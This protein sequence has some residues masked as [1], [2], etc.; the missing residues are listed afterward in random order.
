L[1]RHRGDPGH[2]R[3]CAL[4]RGRV[5]HAFRPRPRRHRPSHRA[6]EARDPL[7]M[8]HRLHAGDRLVVATHN[9][10][11]LE[12]FAT[13]LAPHRLGVLLSSDLG[14]PEPEETSTTFEDNA[15]L[16]AIAAAEAAKMP[17]LADDSGVVVDALG[18]DPGVYSAR[19]AGP[20]KDFRA[21]MAKV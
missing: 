3:G 4:H 6:A 8:P 16:K 10:G 5:R 2:G 14:L 1:R 13:L 20:E 21:A 18:G 15:R 9:R 17:A 11:K 7:T 12:E 19:W